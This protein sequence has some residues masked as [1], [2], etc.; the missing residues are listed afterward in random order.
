MDIS[1]LSTQIDDYLLEKYDRE[2]CF[3]VDLSN[4]LRVY[5]DDDRPGREIPSTWLRLRDYISKEKVDIVGFRVR[6][7]SNVNHIGYGDDGYYF[8]HAALF[9]FGGDRVAE[10]YT[11][12]KLKNGILS[13][14]RFEKPAMDI[15]LSENRD[16]K[17]AKECLIINPSIMAAYQLSQHS[18]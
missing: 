9:S 10:Y 6:F 17:E 8:A 7:R 3:E 15:M 4:G 13:V 11:A 16:W 2:A 14:T 5:S 12:G 1:T 18:I